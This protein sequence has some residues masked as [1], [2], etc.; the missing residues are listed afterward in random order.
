MEHQCGANNRVSRVAK[1]IKE[2]FEKKVNKFIIVYFMRYMI[3]VSFML[4]VQ[5]SK[6]FHMP[7]G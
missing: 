5:S 4:F 1:R 2:E 3:F 7:A 6:L